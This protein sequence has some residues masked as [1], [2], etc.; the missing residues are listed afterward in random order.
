MPP[1]PNLISESLLVRETI[2]Y[3]KAAGGSASAVRVVDR[4]M[5]I[6]KVDPTLAVSLISDLIDRDPR[7]MLDGENVEF[8]GDAPH[9]FELD[10]T[11]FV[12]LDL[13]TTGAKAPP[14]R[15]IEIG[16]YRVRNG[17]IHDHFHRLVN[18]LM[19]IPRFVAMLTG[20][21][22]EMV[23]SAPR[24]DEVA[25]DLMRFIGKSVIV[26]HN[27]QFDMGFLNHEIAKVYGE[28]RLSNPSLCTVQLARSL[29][30]GI[31]NHKLRT[32]ANYYSIE[33]INHHRAA[34]DAH[35]TA[36]ILIRLLTE[37]RSLGVKDLVAARKLPSKKK[38]YAEPS[39][40]AA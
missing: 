17:E 29:I 10:E 12:V 31:D 27:S 15:I 36:H 3:L 11:D 7:L 1:F 40:A 18:P 33:L 39:K 34:D 28:Y 14:S 37:L 25:D 26:A 35:A 4:V 13:E 9:P 22:D 5:K 24:F 16:A 6:R 2:Q 23:S 8:L 21:S 30:S 32:V 20:I 38:E 19:P